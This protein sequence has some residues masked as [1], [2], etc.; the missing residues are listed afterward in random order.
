MANEA[1]AL[2]SLIPAVLES[3]NVDGKPRSS[4]FQGCRERRARCMKQIPRMKSTVCMY[5]TLRV[6]TTMYISAI[7]YLSLFSHPIA[8]SHSVFLSLCAKIIVLS[9]VSLSRR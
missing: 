5:S 6:C 2:V 1:M 8:N 7:L 9:E 3:S 4:I